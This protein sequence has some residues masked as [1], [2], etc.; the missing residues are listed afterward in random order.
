VPHFI[1]ASGFTQQIEEFCKHLSYLTDDVV[2]A[3]DD[4]AS[5]I[6]STSYL[7]AIPHARTGVTT[8]FDY[9][10]EFRKVTGGWLRLRYA[11]ELR[12][13]GPGS[14]TLHARRAHHYHAPWGTHQHCVTPSHVED[15]HYA[16]VERLLQ[17]THEL[18]VQ[19]FASGSPIDCS[20][21]VP[22]TAS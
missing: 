11:Y 14:T 22:L 20:G 19:Q 2:L 5:P 1:P 3:D 16:D 9:R 13:S 10:E 21:L 17:A 6:R 7:V 4:R 18:F 15:V 12:I 8:T